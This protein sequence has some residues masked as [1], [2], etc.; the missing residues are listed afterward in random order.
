MD[1]DE[2]ERQAA[3]RAR[4]EEAIEAAFAAANESGNA[5]LVTPSARARSSASR[6]AFDGAAFDRQILGIRADLV[7]EIRP[8]I[9]LSTIARC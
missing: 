1:R 7:I 4:A 9:S 8:D 6:R 3:L 2:A 5:F